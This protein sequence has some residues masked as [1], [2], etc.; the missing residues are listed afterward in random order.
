MK[1]GDNTQTDRDFSFDHTNYKLDP[2]IRTRKEVQYLK[3][4]NSTNLTNL[5]FSFTPTYSQG[6]Q[7]QFC[8]VNEA[9]SI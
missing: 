9:S 5:A 2:P 4:I 3:T 7:D 1:V 6:S 8:T